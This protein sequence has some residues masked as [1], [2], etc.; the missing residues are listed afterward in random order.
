MFISNFGGDPVTQLHFKTF[1]KLMKWRH[2]L[3]VI[4]TK[5]VILIS[6]PYQPKHS[7]SLYL[8]F[9]SAIRYRLSPQCAICSSRTQSE[10]FAAHTFD[11]DI[12]W[13]VGS[14]YAC[15]RPVMHSRG[16]SEFAD[17]VTHRYAR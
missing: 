14:I 8:R 6:Q 15:T 16:P 11:R 1:K 13:S 10:H 5:L 7:P 2:L 4:T 9:Q 17:L 3:N 12:D